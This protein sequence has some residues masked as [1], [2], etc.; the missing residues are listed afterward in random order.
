[1]DEATYGPLAG[2]TIGVTAARRADELIA[3]LRLA[4]GRRW[5]TRPPCGSCPWPT[6]AN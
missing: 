3:L 4:A 2:F 5:C 6:T 1:M